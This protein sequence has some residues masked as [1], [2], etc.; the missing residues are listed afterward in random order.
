MARDV[1]IPGNN[2]S[3]SF[4]FDYL[5]DGHAVPVQAHPMP[6]LKD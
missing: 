1:I 3:R 6:F 4:V 5:N 2:F